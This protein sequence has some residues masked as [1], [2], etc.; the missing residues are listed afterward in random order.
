MGD[1]W[2]TPEDWRVCELLNADTACWDGVLPIEPGLRFSGDEISAAIVFG[3]AERCLDE[4]E[5]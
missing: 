1:Q 2:L 3:L 4:F 5:R